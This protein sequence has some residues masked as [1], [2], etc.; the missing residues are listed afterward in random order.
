M[1]MFSR[2]TRAIV[3]PPA[4]NFAEG[5][6]T[7]DL[8]APDV[9]IA[10]QQHAAYCDALAR[11]GCEVIALPADPQHPDSTFVE[12]TALILPGL[13][14][15][16]TRPGAESRAGEVKAMRIA[17]QPYFAAMA[18]LE[19]PGT[20]DAGD[21][22]EAGTHVFIGL[23]RRT[24][25][26]GAAQLAKWL[27][28]FGY[29]ASTVDIRGTDDILHLKSGIAAIDPRRLVVIETLTDHPAFAGYD[30]VRVPTGEEYGANCVRVNEVLFVSRGQP[31][32]DAELRA[33]GYR[34]EALEMSEYR[35]MDG[36]L[37]CLSLRF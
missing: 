37:S 33:L 17:L 29:T 8:G 28:H 34:L 16:L 35:K 21:V 30:I 6:T 19:A 18:Q 11:H 31:G 1:T 5:L 25:E 4:R 10:L 7:V 13:G 36:G 2:F 22:C 23:S 9:N 27:T 32:L 26:S 12:D 20:L 24:N 14:A 3:R 15:M